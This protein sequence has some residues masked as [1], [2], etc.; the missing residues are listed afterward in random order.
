MSL[1]REWD[2]RRRAA[3]RRGFV[4]AW[5]VPRG[6]AGE[7]RLRGH[8][9]VSAGTSGFA[10][11]LRS[12]VLTR[13]VR[14]RG[15]AVHVGLGCS[16]WNTRPGGGHQPQVVSTF[17]PNTAR[18]P[19]PYP[20]REPAAPRASQARDV[21]R[22]TSPGDGPGFR[23]C[24]HPQ[25]PAA[26]PRSLA[27]HRRSYSQGGATWKARERTVPVGAGLQRTRRHKTGK[28]AA[29]CRGPVPR[30]TSA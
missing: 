22:G 24:P 8:P 6:T 2:G 28:T 29:A 16:T 30:G 11:G 15:G 23:G 3:C 7:P 9:E 27:I 14:A 20:S 13:T 4:G 18:Q 10:Q 12:V 17:H 21:P 25:F 1:S 19:D 5:D 26:R